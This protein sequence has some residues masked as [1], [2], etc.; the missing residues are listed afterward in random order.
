MEIQEQTVRRYLKTYLIKNLNSEYTEN[1][2]ISVRRQSDPKMGR[3][4]EQT[5]HKGMDVNSQ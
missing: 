2:Y 3:R 4:L 5:V 1:S